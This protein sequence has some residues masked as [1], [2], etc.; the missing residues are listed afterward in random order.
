MLYI[1]ACVIKLLQHNFVKMMTWAV[2]SAISGV[3][4]TLSWWWRSPSS[5]WEWREWCEKGVWAVVHFVR[6]QSCA[7]W[8]SC[9][10]RKIQSRKNT[11]RTK[12]RG[13]GHFFLACY[14]LVSRHI[15]EPTRTNFWIPSIFPIHFLVA[16]LM[17]VRRKMVEG[18]L[19]L[20]SFWFCKIRLR[21]DVAV[22]RLEIF[23][24]IFYF[25]EC[26]FMFLMGNGFFIRVI[27]APHKT[28]Q[29]VFLK[30]SNFLHRGKEHINAIKYNVLKRTYPF[31]GPGYKKGFYP[32]TVATPWKSSSTRCSTNDICSAKSSHN[33]PNKY[34]I[35]QHCPLL[36]V[37]LVLNKNYSS[38]CCCKMKGTHS[39]HFMATW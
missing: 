23:L 34:L 3:R 28:W 12:Q 30:G 18:V 8:R 6:K 10:G 2:D 32:T 22:L 20:F 24:P 31:S 5:S 33:Y 9:R 4:M 17:F 27:V 37:K 1:F 26:D 14:L 25:G 36:Q 7:R 16:S 19:F 11:R 39:R 15:T 29:T 21:C 13:L 35:H 38:H